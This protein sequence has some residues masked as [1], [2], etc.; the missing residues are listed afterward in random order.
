MK[1][2]TFQGKFYVNIKL[3]S[4][5]YTVPSKSR[6]HYE[7]RSS[8]DIIYKQNIRQYTMGGGKWGRMKIAK[9]IF[10]VEDF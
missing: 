10:C 8:E 7:P 5:P 4:T 3:W 1:N 2:C 6:K 9:Q